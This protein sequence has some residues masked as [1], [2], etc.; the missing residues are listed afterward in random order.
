MPW[1][2]LG[3]ALEHA[4]QRHVDALG[5]RGRL[6]CSPGAILVLFWMPREGY[7]THLGSISESMFGLFLWERSWSSLGGCLVGSRNSDAMRFIMV[8]TSWCQNLDRH[9]PKALS[10]FWFDHTWRV[11]LSCN[12]HDGSLVIIIIIINNKVTVTG[13]PG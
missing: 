9:S 8:D 11:S 4:R 12:L 13:L 7:R 3:S 5:A 10:L 1:E 6:R 2:A